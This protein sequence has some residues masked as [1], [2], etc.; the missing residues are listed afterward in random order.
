MGVGIFF[1]KSLKLNCNQFCQLCKRSIESIDIDLYDSSKEQIVLYVND[2]QDTVQ[3]G[4]LNDF[5]LLVI[6]SD[7]FPPNH[8]NYIPDEH[9]RAMPFL[10]QSCIQQLQLILQNLHCCRLQEHGHLG[11]DQDP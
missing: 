5:D 1:F 8:Q 9:R 6:N 2:L 10:V 7:H 4:F 11:I 3:Y